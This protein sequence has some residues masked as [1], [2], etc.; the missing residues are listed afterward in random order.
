MKAWPA[1]EYEEVGSG[2]GPA[3]A[4]PDS[5]SPDAQRKIGCKIGTAAALRQM[6]FPPIQYIVPEVLAEGCTILAGLPKLGKS[7][8]MLDIGL[9]VAAGGICLGDRQCEEGAVLYLGLED[10]ERRL[11]RRMDK[12]LGS[13]G[14]EWPAAFQ[15]SCA[16]PRANEGGLIGIREWLSNAVEAAPRSGR[17]AGRLSLDTG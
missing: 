13:F 12:I 11:Q 16:W 15:Y 5:Y 17:R 8:M 3:A 9:A 4:V 7:W 10:N 2:F 6:V 14:G 1:G